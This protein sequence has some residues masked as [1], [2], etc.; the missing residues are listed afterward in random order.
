MLGA[1]VA[2]G[3]G[4]PGGKVGGGEVLGELQGKEEGVVG[5][6]QQA[7]PGGGAAER[8]VDRRD[9]G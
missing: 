8:A 4:E 3:L 5:I 9:L 2:R 7:A 6:A 1:V